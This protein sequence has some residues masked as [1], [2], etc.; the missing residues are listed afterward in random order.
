LHEIEGIGK[1]TAEKLLLEFK[2]VKKVREA[3][4][5]KIEAVIGKDKAAKLQAYFQGTR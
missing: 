1:A 4:A 2:S 3:D 5:A